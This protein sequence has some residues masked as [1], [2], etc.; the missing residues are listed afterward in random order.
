MD[1]Q[2]SLFDGNLLA[3]KDDDELASETSTGK[4]KVQQ[5]SQNMCRVGAVRANHESV[6][7]IVSTEAII[8]RVPSQCERAHLRTHAQSDPMMFFALSA[9]HQ[10]AL[11]R[12]L[13]YSLTRSECGPPLIDC[14]NARYCQQSFTSPTCLLYHMPRCFGSQ[15]ASSFRR[16]D[17]FLGLTKDES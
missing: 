3:P 12:R 2:P 16:H 1:E 5:S 14:L 4:L 7:N 9:G 8:R 13:H 6:H 11:V 17:Y 10:R 15:H